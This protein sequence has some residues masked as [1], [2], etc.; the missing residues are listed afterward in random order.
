MKVGQYSGLGYGV[1]L[2]KKVIF[3]DIINVNQRG[4]DLFMEVNLI[5]LPKKNSDINL[6]MK[7]QI[8]QL[9]EKLFNDV[10]D[11]SFLINMIMWKFNI[12]FP[13]KKRIW[14]FLN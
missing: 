12:R 8:R 5:I 2:Q 6:G 4:C 1:F 14:S 10:N 13:Q 11:S 7:R 3:E 9:F